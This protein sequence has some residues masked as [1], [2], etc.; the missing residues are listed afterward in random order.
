MKKRKM[1]KIKGAIIAIMVVFSMLF[2]NMQ[3]VY[4]VGNNDAEVEA[5]IAKKKAAGI[6]IYELTDKDGVIVG[7]IESGAEV[8]E[9]E[10]SRYTKYSF[11]WD[12]VPSNTNV[13][14]KSYCH[15]FAKGDKM[16]ATIYQNPSG[17]GHYSCLGVWNR[18]KDELYFSEA[19]LSTN[20][21]NN[22][23][24]NITRAGH[25]ALAIGN[26]SS[27]KQSYSGSYWF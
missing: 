14:N 24:I 21:W 8:Q 5:E 6:E 13:W 15:S 10:L 18:E 7:Y 16:Y 23:T 4:A 17:T 26:L 3:P 27:G 19:S 20:G 1:Q 2:V 22:V 25:Y 12:D 11:T 9:N